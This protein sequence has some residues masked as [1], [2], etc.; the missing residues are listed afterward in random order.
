M[1]DRLATTELSWHEAAD[2]NLL[3]D[4]LADSIIQR[5]DSSIRQHGGASLVVSG[6][7]TPAP[8]F[9][10]L[11]SADI[12][13]S[14][15]SVTLADERWVPPGHVDSNESLVRDTLLVD[16]A[17]AA[18]FV[19]LYRPEIKSSDAVAQI[20][21]DLQRMVWPLTVVILGM[22]NDGHTASLFPD[23]PVDELTF[24]MSLEC[25]ELVAILHPPSVSQTRISL[26]RSALLHSCH[27]FL[28]ITGE[29]KRDVLN[30][31]LAGETLPEYSHGMAPVV[32]LLTES[33]A[34]TSIYWSP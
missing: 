29:Q 15:V 8:V 14:A 7:S 16:K 10:A 3:A 6:G 2:K 11:S 34:K 31:A 30:S 17:T 12:D 1:R 9:S 32:G 24:A 27:R 20:T 25:K 33:P 28:H 13:W 26:T 5:L 4:A 19:P 21:A 23:A 22:G 18:Q